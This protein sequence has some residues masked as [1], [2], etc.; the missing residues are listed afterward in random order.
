MT[1]HAQEDSA[2]EVSPPICSFQ[3]LENGPNLRADQDVQCEHNSLPH[4]SVFS[5]TGSDNP[6][7]AHIVP[8]I[9]N[10]LKRSLPFRPERSTVL[11][12]L[13]HE[14]AELATEGILFAPTSL[15]WHRF[16]FIKPQL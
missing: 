14:I 3:A 10:I 4:D 5:R 16:C 13:L 8:P 6:I 2:G 1:N 9:H 11:A 15:R 12:R 7:F